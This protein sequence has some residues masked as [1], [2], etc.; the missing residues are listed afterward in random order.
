MALAPDAPRA[1][2]GGPRASRAAACVH[3]GCKGGG[4]V[5]EGCPH[6]EAQALVTQRRLLPLHRHGD[7]R[8]AGARPLRQDPSQRHS[9]L[10][11]G[12][13]HDTA[14]LRE[15]VRPL[16]VVETSAV[17]EEAQ[18]ACHKVACGADDRLLC[19][20]P[21]EEPVVGRHHERPTDASEPQADQVSLHG[22]LLLGAEDEDLRPT[23]SK[24][25]VTST[26]LELRC[27]HIL[28]GLCTPEG[29][30]RQEA[31]RRGA[32]GWCRGHGENGHST[33]RAAPV[34]RGGPRRADAGDDPELPGGAPEAL[35]ADGHGVTL[36][37]RPRSS[38]GI[39]LDVHPA[40]GLRHGALRVHAVPVLEV[41]GRNVVVRW[42]VGGVLL[43]A[44]LDLLKHRGQRSA[45]CK[46]QLH[47]LG[48]CLP[49]DQQ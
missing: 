11:E 5:K 43:A 25:L 47:A 4:L 31:A 38:T 9:V 36:R 6:A 7:P 16:N 48:R 2:R 12:Y 49:E 30:H 44:V 34:R 18:L 41:H 14:S 15:E 23:R 26:A 39:S 21:C 22:R 46:V 20:S 40:P 32:P 33:G 28:M 37:L 17:V 19:V 29:G 35:L 24:E 10:H 1:S 45:A 27:T 13:L 8:L 3:R 42:R